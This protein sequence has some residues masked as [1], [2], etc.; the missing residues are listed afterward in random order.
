M[1]VCEGTAGRRYPDDES[2]DPF[3]TDY[4]RI[5][6]SY[7]YRRMPYKTQVMPVSENSHMTTRAAHTNEVIAASGQIARE[8]GLNTHLCMAIAAGHDIGHPPYGHSGERILTK[9]GPFKQFRRNVNSVVILQHIEN[10]GE[11]LNL[12]FETLD[13]IYKHA[14]ERGKVENSEGPEEYNAVMSGDKISYVFSDFDDSVKYGY[15][16]VEEIPDELRGLLGKAGERK[17]DCIRALIEE[18][19]QKGRV[20][21]SQGPAFEDFERQRD[22]NYSRIY[23][24]IDSRYHEQDLEN[25]CEYFSR[26]PDFSGVD[27]VLATSLLTDVEVDHFVTLFRRYRKPPKELIMHYGIFEI[28]PCLRDRNIDY[29]DPDLEWGKERAR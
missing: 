29:T 17:M 19:R 1:R 23:P 7:S 2:S 5:L 27:L 26:D 21:F 9:L 8:L 13:G 18:S 28:L 11:G 24:E 14:G 16:S 12:T 15:L 10:G 4:F 25:I 22:F 20:S 3:L 6:Q